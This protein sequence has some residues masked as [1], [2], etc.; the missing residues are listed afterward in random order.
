MWYLLLGQLNFPCTEHLLWILL[1][2]C[3]VSRGLCN[4]RTISPSVFILQ[5]CQPKRGRYMMQIMTW[6]LGNLISK[7]T[8]CKLWWVEIP[9]ICRSVGFRARWSDLAEI[10]CCV[11]VE[12]PSF[13][14]WI[15]TAWLWADMWCSDPEAILWILRNTLEENQ[16]S[17]F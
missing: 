8:T 13:T 12:H 4:R 16:W 5:H 3:F 2:T 1:Q 15:R 6:G 10:N 7:N 17:I 11:S 9:L 14:C